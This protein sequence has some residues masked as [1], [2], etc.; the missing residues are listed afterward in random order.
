MMDGITGCLWQ[1]DREVKHGGIKHQTRRKEIAAHAM[2]MGGVSLALRQIIIVGMLSISWILLRGHRRYEVSFRRRGEAL[3]QRRLCRHRGW[4]SA[5]PV[6]E[7]IQHR[8]QKTK[9]S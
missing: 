1:D 2:T 3:S 8:G 4:S 6:E 9:H 5:H 7:L